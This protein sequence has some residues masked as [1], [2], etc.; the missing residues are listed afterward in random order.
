MG[1]VVGGWIYASQAP[2]RGK[3]ADELRNIG[4]EL[5]VLSH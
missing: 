1:D 3:A 4:V 5:R 2:V